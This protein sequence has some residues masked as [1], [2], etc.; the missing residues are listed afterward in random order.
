MPNGQL[1]RIKGAGVRSAPMRGS[2]SGSAYSSQT[3]TL[4]GADVMGDRESAP[5][6]R[7]RI[8]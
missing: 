4:V 5:K 7:A 3:L 2:M 1:T 6:R 8:A